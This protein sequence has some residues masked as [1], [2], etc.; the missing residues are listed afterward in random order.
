MSHHKRELVRVKRDSLM[1][2]RGEAIGWE[3]AAN[4]YKS[5]AETVILRCK[6]M[7]TGWR[8]AITLLSTTDA[9]AWL[10]IIYLLARRHA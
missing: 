5:G 3:G 9:I 6:Q 2:A 4:L 10:T 7:L 1:Q 8:L